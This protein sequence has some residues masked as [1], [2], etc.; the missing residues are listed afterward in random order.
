MFFL[1]LLDIFILEFFVLS[2]LVLSAFCTRSISLFTFPSIVSKSTV[3]RTMVEQM[4]LA[5]QP[6]VCGD[7]MTVLEETRDTGRHLPSD[8]V[9]V[10][11]LHLLANFS[12]LNFGISIFIF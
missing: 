5:T 9:V 2:R 12:H 1:G 6:K 4:L 3:T 11:L 10:N 8:F 7:T